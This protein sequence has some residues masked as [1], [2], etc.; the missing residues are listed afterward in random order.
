MELKKL[1]TQPTSMTCFWS[2]GKQVNYRQHNELG[3]TCNQLNPKH[4]TESTTT[5]SSIA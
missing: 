2:N 4:T 5:A 3:R 1:M